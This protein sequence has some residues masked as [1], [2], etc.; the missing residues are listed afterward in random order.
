MSTSG[1]RSDDASGIPRVK[2]VDLK[3]AVVDIPVSGVDRAKVFDG[4]LGWRL[5][6]DFPFDNGSRVIEFIPPGSGGWFNSA[7]TSCRPP[8]SARGLYPIVSD[9]GPAGR[10]SR[11]GP[12]PLVVRDAWNA[13]DLSQFHGW[14]K[15]HLSI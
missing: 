2:E 11:V 8:G 4:S 3:L 1:V 5:D 9:I 6:A 10:L 15:R 14:N 12:Q 13:G 7:R